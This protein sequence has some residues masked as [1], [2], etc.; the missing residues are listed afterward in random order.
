[1]KRKIRILK[2]S[3]ASF[4]TTIVLTI[5]FFIL[6]VSGSREFYIL[7]KSTDKYIVC[8]EA[9]KHL[10]DGSDYLTEQVRLYVMTG[11]EKYM[12]LYLKEANETKRR[13]ASLKEL[14]K[15]FDKTAVF[16]SLQN[17]LN[18]SN[19]LMNTEYYAMRLV[20]EANGV[21]KKT[22]PQ[23]LKK[24]SI[25]DQDEA[26]TASEKKD[27]AQ[28]LVCGKTYQDRRDEITNE[29]TRCMQG[30]IKKTK[31]SQGRATTIF[32]DMYIKLQISTA[33][34]VVLMLA[35]CILIR[36]LV[37]GPLIS[38]NDS[39]KRGEIFPVIGAAELQNLAETYNHVYKEN[40][41]TQKLIRHQ[42]E[43]DAMTDLLNRGS[44]EKLL[45]IHEAGPSSYALLLIDVDTF[46]TVN[47]TYGHDMGDQILKK[48]SD[49]LKKTFRSIDYVCRIGGDEFAIIMVEMTS[50]LE[51][52]I[53][54][55]ISVINEKL[56]K[57]EDGLPAVSVSVG[58]AF[59][60]REN[61]GDTIFKDADKA[62]YDVKENGRCGCKIYKG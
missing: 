52:T 3:N 25:I 56:S 4:I 20:A 34:L 40:Q 27:K 59:S 23:E 58:V 18:C 51:Y 13:E 29:V 12:N 24:V 61:P 26:L 48:V 11:D 35:M 32:S 6:A 19:Q 50:D 9:A 47:D 36:K 42:A 2:V 17:A 16:T 15:C 41:E 14:K 22:W 33:V 30:L 39:I 54:D 57:G 5:L 28:K 62:L 60:D 44:F 37:V 45:K 10:Q 1:M 21:S 38:Y 8:E 55:K 43:H 53:L 31:N 46:K 7:K 49:L